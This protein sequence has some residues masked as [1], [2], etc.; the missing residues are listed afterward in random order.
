MWSRPITK[1]PNCY[2]THHLGIKVSQTEVNLQTLQVNSFKTNDP[3]F[4]PSAYSHHGNLW[5]VDIPHG[6]KWST[7]DKKPPL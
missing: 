5:G 4:L 6:R 2:N 7:Q 3:D 1:Q